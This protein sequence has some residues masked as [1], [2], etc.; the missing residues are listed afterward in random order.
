MRVS[1]TDLQNSFGRYLALTAKEDLIVTKNGKSVAKLVAYSDPEHL[2]V[3]EIKGA[4]SFHRRVSYD[5][6]V[7]YVEA[8]DQRWELI[9]GQIHLLASP[10]FH[11]QV[12]VR[13]L[14]VELDKFLTDP[15][16]IVPAPLDVR[17]QGYAL[18]FAE[19]PNVVQPDLVVICDPEYVSEDGKYEGIPTL[20]AEILSPSSRSNDF[21]AKLH[22]Y[23][24]SGIREYWIIDPESS[25]VWQYYFTM[26]RELNQPVVYSGDQQLKSK[27]FP[28]LNIELTE[29]FVSR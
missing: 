26:E 19:D 15:C 24:R 9:D 13:K 25:C 29:I 28:G 2:C 18:N 27:I 21:V 7:E 5:E 8:S 16:Q 11:H 3:N 14:T 1:S 4:Y 10:S 17:L 20:V 12:I 6:F 23:Q 22:L